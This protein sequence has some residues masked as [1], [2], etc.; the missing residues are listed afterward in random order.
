MATGW[1]V[2]G[3]GNQNVAKH[4]ILILLRIPLPAHCQRVCIFCTAPWPHTEYLLQHLQVRPCEGF[5]KLQTVRQPRPGCGLQSSV[6][7]Q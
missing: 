2:S 4:L 5:H 6:P 1:R 7:G 3:H